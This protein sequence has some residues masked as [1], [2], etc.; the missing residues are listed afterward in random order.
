M[1][2]E[3]L[4]SPTSIARCLTRN[5]RPRFLSQEDSSITQAYPARACAL[6]SAR[7]LGCLEKRCAAR[8]GS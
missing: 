6:L 4:S 7:C 2:D 3:K 5:A 8:F 1:L